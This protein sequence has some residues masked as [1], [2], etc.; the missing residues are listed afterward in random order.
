METLTPP[1]KT[2]KGLKI[3]NPIVTINNSTELEILA[4]TLDENYTIIDFIYYPPHYYENGGWVQINSDTYIRAVGTSQKLKLIKAVNIPITPQ[5]HYF[6]SSKAMLAYTLYFPA[7]PK[8]CKEID[9]IECNNGRIGNWFNFYGVSME[10]I[11]TEPLIVN[12]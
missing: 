2:K 5:K 9:I 4:I 3:Y 7:L 12:N 11:R 1:Q 6:K 10:K 8:S